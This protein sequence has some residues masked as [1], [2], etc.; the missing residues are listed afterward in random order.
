MALLALQKFSH[1]QTYGEHVKYRNIY[2][3]TLP[4]AHKIGKNVSWDNKKLVWLIF[5]V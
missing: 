1:R 4:S 5:S 2:P 3:P